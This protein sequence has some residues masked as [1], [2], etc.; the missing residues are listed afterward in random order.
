MISIANTP[1]TILATGALGTAAFGIVQAMKWTR[2]GTAGFGKIR[3]ALAP[4]LPALERAYGAD[5]DGLLVGQYR[6]E[7]SEGELPRTLRQGIRIGLTEDNAPEMAQFVGTVDG[8]ILQK[9]AAKIEK[10]QEL[11]EEERG[12]LG[13]F[14][15]AVDARIDSALAQAESVY[16]GAVRSAAS[17]VALAIA[18]AT[19][20]VYKTH[21]MTMAVL[22]GI[23]AV[24]LA[25]I[26]KDLS[27]AIQAAANAI[28]ARR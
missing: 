10:G 24:P 18:I 26:A 13:R 5:Y 14:E 3:T 6:S 19:A 4:L 23:A 27:S 22:I 8:E 1:D 25:P 11:S 28:K 16:I 7:R 17:L 9:T 20:G 21:D 2:L 15:L 12:V